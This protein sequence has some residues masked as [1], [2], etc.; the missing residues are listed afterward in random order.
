L[1]EKRKKQVWF[2]SSI[3]EKYVTFK[4][5]LKMERAEYTCHELKKTVLDGVFLTQVQHPEKR[6]VGW[7][8]F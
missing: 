4:M 5:W 8:A 6:G 7:L 3:H 2:C 1:R